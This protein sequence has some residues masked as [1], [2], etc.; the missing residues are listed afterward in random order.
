M[1]AAMHIEGEEPKGYVP[2]LSLGL[3]RHKLRALIPRLPAF[4]SSAGQVVRAASS[5]C[6][7]SEKLVRLAASDPVL[8]G[9]F[10]AAANSGSSSWGGTVGTVQKAAMYLGEV[11][12]T[13]VLL[14]VALQPVLSVIGHSRLWEHSLEAANVALRLAANSTQFAEPDAYVLGLL[15]DIGELLFRLAPAEAAA[16]VETLVSR[17]LSRPEAEA[18]VYGASHAQAGS[19]ILQHWGLPDE[20]RTA[21][22]FH[23]NPEATDSA[24]AALLYL[25]EQWTDPADDPC[26]DDRL[27]KARVRL[28]LPDLAAGMSATPMR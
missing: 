4:P 20:Y 2:G 27:E 3:T 15:H 8:A 13:Q 22:E 9:S 10:I 1:R 23:H 21:V 17:G 26:S 24:G 12:G 14:R 19:D 11:K 18:T 25:C 6:I 16:G 5:G 7:P 28:H